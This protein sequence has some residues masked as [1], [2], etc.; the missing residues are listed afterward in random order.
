[1][2]VPPAALVTSVIGIAR[3]RAKAFA[4]VGTVISALFCLPWLLPLIL[5]CR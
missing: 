3:D 4:I 1:M 2:F 5:L